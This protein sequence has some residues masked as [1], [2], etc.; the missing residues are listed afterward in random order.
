MRFF[1]KLYVGTLLILTFSLILMSYFTIESS[2]VDGFE[3]AKQSGLQQHQLVKLAI[4]SE[5]VSSG[6]T[7]Y[8][9]EL[10]NTITRQI[11]EEMSVPVTILNSENNEIYSALS[12]DKDSFKTVK[13]KIKYIVRR[14]NGKDYLVFSSNLDI[15]DKF[16]KFISYSRCDDV[17]ENAG[18]IQKTSYRI[19]VGALSAGAL[20]TVGFSFLITRPIKDLT[21]VE[22]NFMGGD[23]KARANIFPGDEIG[24]LSKSFNLMADSIE[25]KIEKLELAIKQKEDFTAAFAHELKTPMTSIIGYA[26]TIY[27]REMPREEEKK[28]AEYILNEGMRLEALAFKLMKLINLSKSELVLEE[29]EMTEFFDDVKA[30]ILPLSEKRGIAVEF[31][32]YEGYVKIERDLFKTMLM[33]LIDNAFKSGTESVRVTGVHI[34]DNYTFTVEDK[35]RGI[36]ADQVKRVTEAFYM[37]DKARSRQENGAGLGLSLCDKIA[38]VHGSHLDIESEEGVGT[39]I[40]VTLKAVED[41]IDEED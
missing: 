33:N 15:E 9:E 1:T 38:Q 22:E 21:K 6:S 36:P 19:F 20:F 16:V 39:K 12:A 23:Y 34:G 35:G 30:T 18:N 7:A 3:K 13:G 11:S 28:A 17:F 27:Q 32:A 25:D 14:I 40:S 8:N 31:S 5:L 41:E 2:I 37:V 10:L 29:T 24:D 4:H 26:D